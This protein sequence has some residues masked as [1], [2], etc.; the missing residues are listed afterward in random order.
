VQSYNYTSID[1]GNSK[2]TLMLQARFSPKAIN[3][4]LQQA[5]QPVLAKERPLSVV[6]IA[7]ANAPG[8]MSLLNE[9]NALLDNLQKEAE[10]MALPVLWPS[11]DLEDL[12][13]ISAQ[14]V[15]DFAQEAAIR[16]SQRYNAEAIL[17]GT[18]EKMPNNSW[19]GKWLWIG[20]QGNQ[21]WL[22]SGATANQAASNMLK[23]LVV[24]S[25]PAVIE[26]AVLGHV[27]N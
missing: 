20:P 11:M 8:Q 2:T 14:Q 22:T 12:Q 13:A 7:M 3:N 23:Q 16:A 4:L 26:E 1:A 25:K 15:W 10:K 6:W 5:A 18:M 24:V 19:Q 27:V 17:L 9:E 21:S